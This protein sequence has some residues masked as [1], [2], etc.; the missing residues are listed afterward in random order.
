MKIIRSAE[1]KAECP[2]GAINIAN[3]NGVTIGR[4]D[5]SI[6]GCISPLKTHLPR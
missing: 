2:W 4:P 3:M 6:Y 5:I 1:F